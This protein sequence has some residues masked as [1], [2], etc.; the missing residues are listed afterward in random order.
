MPSG[1]PCLG[2]GEG[3]AVVGHDDDERVVENALTPEFGDDLAD[4][5]VEARHF[6][7]VAGEILP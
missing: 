5:T 6:V 1:K 2:T 7:I 3:T 4:E